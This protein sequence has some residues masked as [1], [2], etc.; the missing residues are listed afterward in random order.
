M[1]TTSTVH[2]ILFDMITVSNTEYGEHAIGFLIILVTCWKSV[3]FERVLY[4]T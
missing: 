2:L 4:E 1:R 3:S